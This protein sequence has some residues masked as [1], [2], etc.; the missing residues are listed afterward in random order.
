MTK[1][2]AKLA[3]GSRPRA[4]AGVAVLLVALVAAACA[5]TGSATRSTSSARAAATGTRALTS[6]SAKSLAISAL[7][8]I[9]ASRSTELDLSLAGSA[10]GSATKLLESLRLVVDASSPG[11]LA[12]SRS[13]ASSKV[14]LEQGSSILAEVIEVGGTALYVRVDPSAL[15]RLPLQLTPSQR[16]ELQGIA[17][18]VGGGWYELPTSLLGTA[19]SS[20]T[21]ESAIKPAIESELAAALA[22]AL[23]F[24]SGPPPAGGGQLIEVRSTVQ[25]LATAMLPVVDKIMKQVGLS[26]TMP[27][28]SEVPSALGTVPVDL[29]GTLTLDASGTLTRLQLLGSQGAATVDLTMGVAHSAMTIAAPPGAVAVPRSWLKG[30]EGLGLGSPGA[31]STT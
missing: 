25:A 1:P 2:L 9:G 28:A 24:S 13:D 14:E 30:L 20:S 16:S 5:G 22:S 3:A 8:S 15:L 11:T 26:T 29:E 17:A 31:S 12:S 19:R 23:K 10:F 21:R 27:S 18:L 6:V 4:A 7:S